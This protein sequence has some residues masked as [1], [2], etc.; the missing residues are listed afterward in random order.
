MALVL[1]SFFVKDAESVSDRCW[2]FE[3]K[4]VFLSVDTPPL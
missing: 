2:S 3:Y 1:G 4:L